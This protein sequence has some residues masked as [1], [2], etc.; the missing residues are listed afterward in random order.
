MGVAGPAHQ[1]LL[2]WAARRMQSDGFVVAGFDEHADQGGHWNGLPAPF[3]LRG[4]RPDAW[5]INPASGRL[6]FAE[7]KTAADIMSGRTMAQLRTFGSVRMKA[8]LEA[9]PLYI[10][11]PR[12]QAHR[13]DRALRAT[14]LLNAAHLVRLH[15]PEVLLGSGRRA[16]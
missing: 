8:G 3:S 12:E 1:A 16:A 11:I 10:A 15:V 13:L 2:L 6:A 9:C 5:G 7:A 4:R 14:G